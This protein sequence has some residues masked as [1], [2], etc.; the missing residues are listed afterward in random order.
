MLIRLLFITLFSFQCLSE[1]IKVMVVDTGTDL[2]WPEISSHVK[3]LINDIDYIDIDSHGT[4]MA[5]LVVKDT[6]K[7]VELISCR[8]Y[9]VP[10]KYNY[11]KASIDCFK[12]AFDEN[13]KY[14]NYSSSG[15]EPNEE[16]K[17]ILQQLSDKGATITVS[18]GN[19]KDC[20]I[21]EKSGELKCISAHGEN[22][23]NPKTKKCEGAYPACY[24][25]NNVYIIQN[26]Y[27]DGSLVETSNYLNHP[28][29]RSEVGYEVS[30]LYPN[31]RSGKMT[32][33]SP[34]TAKYMNKLL[35]KE[36]EKIKKKKLA[37]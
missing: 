23:I 3:E 32:G 22:L 17:N 14:I 1:S 21:D 4:A 33:T 7:E 13:I 11:V 31:G 6:C 35:K 9:K 2:S 18:A 26:I 37:Y 36:C 5:G 25:I 20:A 34:A 8:Y 30:V 24:L 28:N 16:E 27:E 12:R 19:G 29:V 10:F 15:G